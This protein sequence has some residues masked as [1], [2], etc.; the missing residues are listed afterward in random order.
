MN[1]GRSLPNSL[2]ANATVDSCLLAC[3]NAGFAVCGSSYYRECY[4][5]AAISS[6]STTL[7]ASSCTFKCDNNAAETC[8]GSGALDVYQ[9]TVVSAL[10]Y[11]ITLCSSRL[12]HK[13]TRLC[14]RS[15]QPLPTSPRTEAGATL[16]ATATS[17]D[18]T[19]LGLFRRAFKRRT[20]RSRRASTRARPRAPPPAGCRTRE[21]AGARPRGSRTRAV[22]SPRATAGTLA[23]PTR[24]SGA[25]GTPLCLST[26]QS[27][28]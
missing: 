2:S 8:G 15:R 6:A 4:G 27:R 16:P 18:R 1:G 17:R 14:R 12:V 24:W 20:P 13:L 23:R 28:L 7:P 5:G 10:V 26:C 19:E 3:Q 9:S 22:R 25:A 21:N 11:F